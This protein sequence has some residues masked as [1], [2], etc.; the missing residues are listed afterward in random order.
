MFGEHGVDMKKPYGGTPILEIVAN[1]PKSLK[2]RVHEEF[3]E[4]P[5]DFFRLK[6]LLASVCEAHD[7][8]AQEGNLVNICY[9]L[10]AGPLEKLTVDELNVA[11]LG[12]AAIGNWMR[13]V[14]RSENY[15]MAVNVV[16]KPEVTITD[17]HVSALVEKLAD[18]GVSWG[19]LLV[20]EF[21]GGDVFR[22]CVPE[23]DMDVTLATIEE[24]VSKLLDVQLVWAPHFPSSH[25]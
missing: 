11:I 24:E 18:H 25:Q 19:A 17:Y 23:L 8:I 12:F 1:E 15:D 21:Y 13:I 14:R 5:E 10:A 16:V 2:L 4:Q 22:L 20:D 9:R 6:L 3:S 7:V